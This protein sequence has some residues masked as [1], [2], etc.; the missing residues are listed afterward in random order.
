MPGGQRGHPPVF[1]EE[2][3]LSQ[4]EGQGGAR[5]MMVDAGTRHQ[6]DNNTGKEALLVE[7][8]QMPMP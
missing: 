2:P 7:D 8:Y 1:G 6:P 4:S 5:T 3:L